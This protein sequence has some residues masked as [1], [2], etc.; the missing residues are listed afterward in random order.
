[1]VILAVLGTAML[2]LKTTADN[3]ELLANRHRAAY[4]AAES[5]GR[6][7]I[8]QIQ[9]N[10]ADAIDD[11]NG[12]TYTFADG[13]E[14]TLS[15][16]AASDP[17]NTLLTSVGVVNKGQWLESR[18]SLTYQV[19][20]STDSIYDRALFTE[21]NVA[22]DHFSF[23][24]EGDLY[25]TSNPTM[26]VGTH[27]GTIT[28]TVG[29]VIYGQSETNVERTLTCKSPPSTFDTIVFGDNL[30]SPNYSH[31]TNTAALFQVDS[32]NTADIYS[33]TYKADYFLIC[34][35]STLTVHGDVVFY[36][37]VQFSL[38][39]GKI[40]LAPNATLTVYVGENVYIKLSDTSINDGGEPGNFI[41]YGT[42][43]PDDPATAPTKLITIAQ[44]AVV[45]GIIDA[46]SHPL[47]LGYYDP[48]KFYGA[49][50]GLS[51]HIFSGF[52]L[53]YQKPQISGSVG[54]GANKVVQYFTP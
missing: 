25:D 7:A 17:D 24:A 23:V 21:N 39:H 41:L 14:F 33:G 11:L 45:Y 42:D 1:M 48:A 19:A 3:S 28:T 32:T 40:I 12:K 49:M 13:Y 18:V 37:P 20:K 15:I 27:N 36:T 6:Y 38:Q 26:L 5:G 22:M 4:Y 10:V 30:I 47:E 9:N 50:V 54:G 51:A 44:E 35:S 46:P 43:T 29:A 53:H 52:G 2:R 16:D 31:V 8:P 34:N